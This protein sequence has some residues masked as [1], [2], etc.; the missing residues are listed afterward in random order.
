MKDSDGMRIEILII[1]T[2][3][4]LLHRTEVFKK[5]IDDFYNSVL[6]SLHLLIKSPKNVFEILIG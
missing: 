3:H 6:S 1:V 5:T 2:C 4:Q